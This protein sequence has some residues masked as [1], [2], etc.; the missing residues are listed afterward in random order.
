[1]AGSMRKLAAQ[2][3]TLSPPPTPKDMY[4]LLWGGQW[5]HLRPTPKDVHRLLGGSVDPPQRMCTNC[6]G[7]RHPRTPKGVVYFKRAPPPPE[8][9]RMIPSIKL[10]CFLSPPPPRNRFLRLGAHLVQP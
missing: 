9:K 1:M 2:L 6:W 10:N 8:C 7:S 3:V 4:K 5:T